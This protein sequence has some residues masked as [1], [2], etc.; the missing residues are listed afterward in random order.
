M[1]GYG[2]LVNDVRG[3]PIMARNG[4][5]VTIDATHSCQQP[6]GKV[7]S[8]NR[9]MAQVIAGASISTG[10]AGVFAEVHEDP[11]NAPSD[12]LN[13]IRLD[14]LENFLARLVALDKVAKQYPMKIENYDITA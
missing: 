10:I 1:F 12:A 8:G 6:S 9:D 2:T 5:P 3:L 7:T 4:V 11:A 13:M 14:E